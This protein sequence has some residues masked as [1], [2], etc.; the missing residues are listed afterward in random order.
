M[1]DRWVYRWLVPSGTDHTKEYVVSV[2]RQ[3]RYGCS[4]WAWRRNRTCRH[5]E[6]VMMDPESYGGKMPVG[7]QTRQ[8]A[9]KPAPKGGYKIADVL[10][11]RGAVL[12]AI[13]V[14]KEAPK[15]ALDRL[16]LLGDSTTA[17]RL[18]IEGVANLF[19]YFKPF[20]PGLT[21]TA[22]RE[23]FTD[24]KEKLNARRIMT[25]NNESVDKVKS[26][27]CQ[28]IAGKALLRYLHAHNPKDR[29]PDKEL[30]QRPLVKVIVEV[31]RGNQGFV[32]SAPVLE[33]NF[34]NALENEDDE[35]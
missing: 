34:G 32:F 2:D 11:V 31:Y 21:K 7:I 6:Q 15:S 23:M 27:N 16:E 8:P 30:R 12:L 25:A 14:T 35:V 3:G 26:Q 13:E 28:L 29:I 1:G 24:Y 5:I 33:S 18:D 17:M 22:L 10:R 19:Q 4:C 9:N 20:L